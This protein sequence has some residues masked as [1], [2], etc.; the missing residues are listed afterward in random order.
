MDIAEDKDADGLPIG[1]PEPY[2]DVLKKLK[3]ATQETLAMSKL[4]TEA[5]Q[6]KRATKAFAKEVGKINARLLKPFTF[7]YLRRTLDEREKYHVKQLMDEARRQKYLMQKA[8]ISIDEIN[9]VM[10]RWQ[11]KITVAE[12]E[13]TE[14]SRQQ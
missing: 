11:E 3:Y 8:G 12:E 10:K 7:V 9:K 13:A 1:D 6:S 2:I 4:F 14:R 5:G